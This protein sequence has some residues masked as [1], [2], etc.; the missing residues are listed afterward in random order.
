MSA[1]E[2]CKVTPRPM[3]RL[4]EFRYQDVD[5]EWQ[6]YMICNA[7]KEKLL[8]MSKVEVVKDNGTN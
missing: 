5:M 2:F 3:A 1:C 8:S 7:C 4:S 6:S